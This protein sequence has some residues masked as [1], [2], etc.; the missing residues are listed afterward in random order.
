MQDAAAAADAAAAD[1]DAHGGAEG[2]H[3]ALRHALRQRGLAFIDLEFPP[4]VRSVEGAPAHDG[5][6]GLL[7]GGFSLGVRRAAPAW[8]KRPEEFL[9]GDA[10][11]RVFHDGL[12]P[13]DVQQG[14]LGNCWF[15]CS[16]AALVEFPPLV[17]A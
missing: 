16:V 4:T 13:A 10:A 6:G 3:G 7:G 5:G 17:R 9:L 1:L 12:A 8:W 2:A 15:M 11:L 14:S